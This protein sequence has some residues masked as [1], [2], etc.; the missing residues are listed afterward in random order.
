M[1]MF[2]QILLMLIGAKTIGLDNIH[3]KAAM[4]ERLNIIFG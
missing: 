3:Q 4:V 1:Y 2:I